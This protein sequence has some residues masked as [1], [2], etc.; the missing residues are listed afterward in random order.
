M[1]L[2]LIL[3]SSFLFS[4]IVAADW[5]QLPV[6][7]VDQEALGGDILLIN[8]KEYLVISGTES[9]T[10]VKELGLENKNSFTRDII[11][12]KS[13]DQLIATYQPSKAR[14][15]TEQIINRYSNVLLKL[16]KIETLN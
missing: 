7:E 5:A 11:M 14:P 10:L 12:T 8:M 15:M 4:Q 3:Y 13:I 16:N 1:K 6:V 2:F 9:A